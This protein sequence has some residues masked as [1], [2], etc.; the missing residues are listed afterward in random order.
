MSSNKHPTLQQHTITNERGMKVTLLNFGARVISIQYPKVIK[1]RGEFVK[2]RITE[3]LEMLLTLP[4]IENYINDT[5]Y[6]GATCGRVCNRIANGEF[7][8]GKQR[9]KTTQNEG[10]HT[11]HGGHDNLA[12]TYWDVIETTASS[13]RMETISPAGESGF[14][15]RVHFSVTFTLNTN[16]ALNIHYQAVTTQTTPIN[17]TNHAYF[18]LGEIDPNNIAVTLFSDQILEKD[19]ANIPTGNIINL[20]DLPFNKNTETLLG[21]VEK[22]QWE[23]ID[24]C[25]LY[26]P[27]GLIKMASAWSSTHDIRLNVYSDAPALHFYTGSGLSNPFKTNTGLC[28][29]AQGY[30]DAVNHPQFPSVLLSPRDKFERVI[31]FELESA[32]N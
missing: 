27:I 3:P 23:N 11:L 6:L 1:G 32:L 26:N 17:L 18:N 15:G 14:P 29:E 2:D 25:F 4:T 20:D 21:K 22:S 5:L 28:F 13:V 30:V 16:N 8:V 7:S 31:V 10:V 19:N 9:Y 12:N 24:D